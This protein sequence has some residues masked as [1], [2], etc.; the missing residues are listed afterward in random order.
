[1]QVFQDYSNLPKDAQNNIVLIGNFDGIH[2]GHQSLITKAKNIAKELGCKITCL[3][4]SPHPRKFFNPDINIQIVNQAKKTEL[5]EKYGIDNFINIQFNQEFS[6]ITGREFIEDILI[7]ELQTNHLIIG[8]DFKF[9][10]KKSGDIE[11]LKK[12][13][14]SFNLEILDKI[15]EDSEIVSSSIIR[16]HLSDGNIAKANKL[17]NWNWEISGEVIHG[18]KRGREI[19]YPTANQLIQEYIRPKLGVYA[20]YAEIKGKIYKAITNI[21]IRPMFKLDI[22]LVETFIFDFNSD[23][24]GEEITIQPF[25]FIRNELKFDNM[26]ELTRQIKEDCIQ[27]KS[28]LE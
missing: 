20:S 21:G 9:G 5:L 14:A 17:L 1:M 16:D 8:S 23:I 22:P 26:E 2:K 19:G 11:L 18:D 27:A 28:M 24:Y 7:K 15:A 25:K 6:E 13:Q 10:Y 4:F 3:S 12:Y